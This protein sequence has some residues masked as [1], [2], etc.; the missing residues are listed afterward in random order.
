MYT[1]DQFIAIYGKRF[2]NYF[3][4]L[5]GTTVENI[6]EPYIDRN[7]VAGDIEMDDGTILTTHYRI[8]NPTEIAMNQEI[9]ADD[10]LSFDDY[11]LG[12]VIHQTV[13]RI[14]ARADYERQEAYLY[15][16]I[17]KFMSFEV[18]IGF[19]SEMGELYGYAKELLP[20]DWERMMIQ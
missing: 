19:N 10:D 20:K 7:Y 3:D 13:N 11:Y 4:H 16:Y 5:I 6:E 12:T 9:P 2:E 1:L 15:F 8:A 14:E 17:S 18:P